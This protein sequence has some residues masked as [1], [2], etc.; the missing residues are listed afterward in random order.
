MNAFLELADRQ[1]VG[2][3]KAR[4][5]AA[6]KRAARRADEQ[7]KLGALWRQCCEERRAAL[8]A[9]E[10]G[11]AARDLIEFLDGMSLHD[12]ATLIAAAK[13]WGNANGDTRHQILALIDR[14]IIALR[15]C[16][17]L[18]PFDDPLRPDESDNVFLRIREVLH[19]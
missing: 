10:H 9:G 6:E 3:R 13:R 12:G 14:A 19:D 5:R 17:N 7:K 8:L 18:P 1:I 4:Q 15:E 16:H 2:P 11:D